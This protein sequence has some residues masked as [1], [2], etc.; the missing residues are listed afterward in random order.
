MVLES[1]HLKT[2]IGCQT[3]LTKQIRTMEYDLSVSTVNSLRPG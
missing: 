2:P 1:T 3:V